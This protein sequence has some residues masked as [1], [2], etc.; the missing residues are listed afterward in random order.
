MALVRTASPRTPVA[1]VAPA[2]LRALGRE[3]VRWSHPAAGIRAA[4]FGEAERREG[5]SLRAVLASLASP[6][7]LPEGMPGP[8]FG[9]AAFDGTLGPDWSGFAPLRFTLPALLAWKRGGRQF[10]AA[11]GDG[12]ASR[13]DDARRRLDRD[14]HGTKASNARHQLDRDGDGTKASGLGPRASGDFDGGA[15]VRVDLDDG[16]A[17]LARRLHVSGDRQH[18]DALVARA[19]A[20]ISSGVLDKVV[21]ARSFDVECSAAID[22]GAVLAALEARY[23]ACRSFLLRGSD[24][25]A[26]LGATPEVLCR[27]EGD[28]LSTEAMAGSAA[29]GSAAALLGSRK[30]LREHRWVVDHILRSLSG[31]AGAVQRKPEPGLRTLANIVHLHTPISARL[32]PGRGVADLAAALHPTPAVAGVPAE[33]ALRFIAQHEELDRGLYAGLIGWVGAD[34]AE[35][36][37][38]LRCALVRGTRARL[39]TG[40]GIVDGSSADQ[41]WEETELKAHALL[42]ALGCAP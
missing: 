38:A 33:A 34:R 36:A 29:P 5:T 28:S 12:A 41:E 39:F 16:V 22:P 26:F 35:L 7:D 30:D 19:L 6:G 27:V 25:S 40:A 14:G 9:A 8:W 42:G 1:E 21:L 13:L 20:A 2:P 11:F 23:P 3:E 18:W 4:A 32:A 37:V 10:L 15:R 24:G 17:V 31:I